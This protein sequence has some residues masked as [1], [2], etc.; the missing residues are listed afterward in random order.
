MIDSYRWPEQAASKREHWLDFVIEHDVLGFFEEPITLKSGKI[1]KWYVN[2]RTATA[3]VFLMDQISQAVLDF[4][5]AQ[6]IEVDCFFGVAEGASKLGVLTQYKAAL[7]SK[8]FAKGSHTLAMGRA[9]PKE[10]G[11]A[12]DRF[13]LGEPRGRVLVLEDVTTTGGSL[14]AC[15]AQLKELDVDIV[16]AL[17][18]TD[19]S[20]NEAG[21][22]TVA[23]QLH[24]QGVPFYAMSHAGQLLPRAVAKHDLD[25]ETR[26]Q[27]V[28]ECPFLTEL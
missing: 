22:S 3:D 15:L 18:L 7:T 23:Q 16:G 25:E 24:K 2:W 4:V 12:K 28:R 1:S 14:F 11:A 13:F 20:L 27:L 8:A 26:A 17:C 6:G 9:K 5:D 21:H 19:R 10:H